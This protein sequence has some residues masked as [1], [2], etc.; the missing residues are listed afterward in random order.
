MNKWV[1]YY[2]LLLLILLGIILLPRPFI[3]KDVD[4]SGYPELDVSSSR[5][6]AMQSGGPAPGTTKSPRPTPQPPPAVNPKAEIGEINYRDPVTGNYLPLINNGSVPVD[7]FHLNARIVNTGDENVLL[8]YEVEQSDGTRLLPL[9]A[10]EWLLKPGEVVY[11]FK[12]GANLKPAGKKTSLAFRLLE[13]NTD[14]MLFQK[15]LSI[16]SR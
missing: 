3:K 4:I 9:G 10:E 7:V 2:G 8:F 5:Q 16:T 13:K 15:E 11:L 12:Q 1:Y 14:K 6:P